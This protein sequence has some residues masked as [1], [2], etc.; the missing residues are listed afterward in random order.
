MPREVRLRLGVQEGDRLELV[1]E[2]GVTVARPWRGEDDPFLEYLARYSLP[3]PEGRTAVQWMRDLRDE[4]D[5]TDAPLR[6][7]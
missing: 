7:P 6:R 3:L 2:G 5:P 1:T 4:D